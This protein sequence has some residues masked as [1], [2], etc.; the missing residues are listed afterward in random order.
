[1]SRIVKDNI[2]LD[3][4]WDLFKLHFKEVNPGFFYHLD[5]QFPGLTPNEQKLCAYYRINL[6]TKEIARMLNITAGSVQKGR[7]RLRKKMNIPS[8][9]EFP[10][11]MSRF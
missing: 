11:F 7:H 3:K 5:K 8:D 6:D 2:N 10:E 1:M 9:V 4:D